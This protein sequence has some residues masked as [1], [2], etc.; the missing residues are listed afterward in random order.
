[1]T[2]ALESGETEGVCGL[3]WSTMKAARPHWIRDNKLNV[4]VQMGLPSCPS[5][6]TCRPRSTVTDPVKKQVLE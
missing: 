5:C 3:S 4:I 6:P 1:M 2:L